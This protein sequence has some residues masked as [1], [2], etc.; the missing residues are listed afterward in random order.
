MTQTAFVA[1][2]GSLAL[3]VLALAA[4]V[5]RADFKRRA[6]IAVRLRRVRREGGAGE[7]AITVAPAGGRWM[8]AVASFGTLLARSG[9]LPSGTLK[10][11][12]IALSNTPLAGT[13]GLPLFIG[14]KALGTV[15][16]LVGAMLASKLLGL[17]APF[18]F[19]LPAGGAMCGLLG[20]DYV[21]GS[22]RKAYVGEVEAGLPDALD[23]LV[24][25]S[26]AGLALD[27]GIERVS[28]EL[29]PAHPAVAREFAITAQEM[30]LIADRA[31]VLT[32]LGQRTGVENLRRLGATLIQTMQFGT[33]ITQ[34]LRTLAVE[35]RQEVMTRY[36]ARAAR[37]PVFLTLPMILFILPCVFI[38]VGGPA[39][40]HV[41]QVLGKR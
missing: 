12:R 16:G 33:P 25:C 21:L 22:M 18:R 40:L 23:M 9:I 27:P 6:A 37:L 4:L 30:R 17:H 38:V 28:L 15:G 34:A 36:E 32:N 8:M 13:N 11:L 24:I 31:Q 41:V 7:P 35:M 3:A 19:L 20:P 14:A 1:F 39:A 2:G 5:L 10:E 29:A 26:E